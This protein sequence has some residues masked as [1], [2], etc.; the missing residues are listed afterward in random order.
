VNN[1]R[2]EGR[3]RRALRA[4]LFGGAVAVLGFL[5]LLW[6]LVSSPP[7]GVAAAQLFIF[8]A[9]ASLIA[10]LAAIARA[11]RSTVPREREDEN[12]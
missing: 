11:T 8:G 9:W 10:M 7:M 3:W 6:P 5:V 4:P 1:P 12:A 2:A